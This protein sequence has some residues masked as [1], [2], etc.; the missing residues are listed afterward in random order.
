M[1]LYL[2][3]RSGPESVHY[4]IVFYIAYIICSRMIVLYSQYKVNL[5]TNMPIVFVYIILFLFLLPLRLGFVLGVSQLGGH[6]PPWHPLYN[7]WFQSEGR[8]LGCVICHRERRGDM[9]HRPKGLHKQMKVSVVQVS[10]EMVAKCTCECQVVV[11]IT[12]SI[13]ITGGKRLG[14]PL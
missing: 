12:S 8:T 10:S 14:G 9:G 3:S 13:Q 1:T 7:I 2:V 11:D 4:G 5:G 6:S